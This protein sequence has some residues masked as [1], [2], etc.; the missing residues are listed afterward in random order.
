[1]ISPNAVPLDQYAFIDSDLEEEDPLKNLGLNRQKSTADSGMG[2]DSSTHSYTT[3]PIRYTYW[4]AK[5]IFFYS[6]R[7]GM[8]EEMDING[9]H[10]SQPQI[11]HPYQPHPLVV[12][13]QNSKSPKEKNGKSDET[14]SGFRSRQ[15]STNQSCSPGSSSFSS[16]AEES[17][18]RKFSKTVPHHPHEQPMH[19]MPTEYQNGAYHHPGSNSICYP[20]GGNMYH[21]NQHVIRHPS[22]IKYEG[23]V[24][25][26]N[27]AQ[28]GNSNSFNEKRELHQSSGPVSVF[29]SP[30]K[31]DSSLLSGIFSS[32][33]LEN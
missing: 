10:L 25:G 8:E 16:E 17:P 29:L 14:D 9:H 28:W 18:T 24:S 7:T 5:K 32:F 22:N 12:M 2:S 26:N 19:S 20:S 33:E 11:Q 13:H 3:S 1:M 27:W 15:N 23:G 6:N 30:L 4:V 31:F 21:Q